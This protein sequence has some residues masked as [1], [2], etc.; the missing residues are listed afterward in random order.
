M[1]PITYKPRATKALRSMPANT[2][3]RIIGKIEAYAADP[4]SQE[5]NVK[6]LKG[7]RAIRL[8]VGDWRVIMQDGIVLDV[9]DIGPRGGI[10]D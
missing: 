3:R 8:R 1:K 4:A 9:L 5:N 6:S 2:A 10:Y 7:S